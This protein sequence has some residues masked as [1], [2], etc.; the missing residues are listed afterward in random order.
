M[1]YDG[2]M[3]PCTDVQSAHAGP[4]RFIARLL[5]LSFWLSMNKDAETYATTCDVCQKI[6]TDHQA[7]MGALGPAHFPP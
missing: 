2:H 6:K 7:K 1:Y 3:N 4:H 5:Q